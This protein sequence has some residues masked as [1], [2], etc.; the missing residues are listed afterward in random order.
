[1]TTTAPPPPAT[2]EPLIEYVPDSDPVDVVDDTSGGDVATV[3]ATVE[4]LGEQFAVREQGV[5]LLALMKFAT[6]AKRGGT[7]DDMEGLAALYALLQTC[8]AEDEWQRFEDHANARGADGE[9][10][11]HVVTGAITAAAARPTQQPSRSPGGQST[12]VPSSGAASSSAGSSI[13]RGDPRVQ[14]DLEAR[15][16]PDLALVVKRAGQAAST[17]SSTG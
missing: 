17:T 13:R 8:I 6:I 14:H 12:T 15:G 7:S 5:S 10:L 2:V 11:M 9:A 1:M 3:V 16:R 4:F